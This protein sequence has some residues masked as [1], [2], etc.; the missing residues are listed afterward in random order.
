MRTRKFHVYEDPGHGWA[1][2][3]V[4]FLE[5]LGVID[6]ITP[7]SYLLGDYAYLEEDADA[8]T[9]VR[10]LEEKGIPHTFT[11][12]HT[13]R[14]SAIRNYP[15]FSRKMIE[16]MKK[17]PQEGMVIDYYGQKYQLMYK[18]GKTWQVRHAGSGVTYL[19]SA[20]QVAEACVVSPAV[21]EQS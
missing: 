21:E 15:A 17:V 20:R 7:Y 1:K 8:S 16:N 13:N 11:T 18:A 10:A 9:F 19:M 4:K 12:H 5:E 2:V 6:D 3:P 14:R